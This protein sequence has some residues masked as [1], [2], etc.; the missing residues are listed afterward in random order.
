[1][2][3]ADRTLGGF[4]G[5]WGPDTNGIRLKRE[6]LEAE[7]CV[8]DDHDA[9]VKDCLFSPFPLD[10]MACVDCT[11]PAGPRADARKTSAVGAAGSAALPKTRKR[12][13]R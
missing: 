4:R 1:V 11:P 10:E 7:G 12:K 6:M 9:V 13:G 2:I 5:D 3:A 8:F